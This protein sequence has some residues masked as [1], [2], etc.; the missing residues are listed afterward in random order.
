MDVDA[1]AAEQRYPVEL[2]LKWEE[3]GDQL[4]G[5]EYSYIQV[6]HPGYRRWYYAT[7]ALAVLAGALLLRLLR[8]RR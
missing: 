4:S 3:D 8:R 1:D 6:L 2:V 5:V 7:G